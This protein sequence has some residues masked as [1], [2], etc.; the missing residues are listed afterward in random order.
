MLGWDRGGWDCLGYLVA[1]YRFHPFTSFNETGR[2]GEV[3]GIGITWK[4]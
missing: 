2:M 3:V 4:G 1:C